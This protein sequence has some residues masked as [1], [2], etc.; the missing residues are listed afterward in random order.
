MLTTT[1]IEE[2]RRRL[3]I[4]GSKDTSFENA[5]PLNGNEILALVQEGVN[6]KMSTRD[7]ARFI[8]KYVEISGGTGGGS[9]DPS[10]FSATVEAYSSAVAEASVDYDAGEFTFKLGLPKG[11]GIPGPVGPQGPEGPRGKDGP[12]GPQGPAGDIAVTSF[13]A[14]TYR[15]Y[16]PTSEKPIPDTPIGGVWDGLNNF[17]HPVGWGPQDGLERPIWKSSRVFFSDPALNGNW[18]TPIQITGDDGSNGTDG[19]SIEFMYKLTEKYSEADKPTIPTNQELWIPENDGWTDDPSG[20]SPTKQCEWVMFRNHLGNG[21]WTDWKGPSLWAKWGDSG[22]DGSGVEY[23]YWLAPE[24]NKGTP[25]SNPTPDN[26]KNNT[27]YQDTIT[28]YDPKNN[29]TDNPTGVSEKRPYEWVCVRKYRHYI[30]ENG[31]ISEEKM[32]LPYEGPTLWSHYGE[33]GYSGYSVRTL[34]AKGNDNLTPPSYTSNN[35]NPGSNWGAFPIDYNEDMVVWAIDGVFSVEGNLVEEW[36]PPRIITGIKGSI[37]VPIYYTSSYFTVP[38]KGAT[39][40]AP[41]TGISVDSTI[42]SK[43]T[44]GQTLTWVDVPNDMSKVWY[45]CV[46]KV[47]SETKKV[48]EWGAV[49]IWNSVEDRVIDGTNWDI[50]V[51]IIS[52]DDLDGPDINRKALNPNQGISSAP[53]KIPNGNEDLIVGEG[54]KMWETKAKFNPDGSF[55]SDGWCYPYP[56]SGEKGPKGDTGPVGDP[57][58]NGVAGISYEE[59]YMRGNETSPMISWSDSYSTLRI[60]SSWNL[61]IPTTNSDYPYIWCIKARINGKNLL[62]DGKW[63]GP[64]RLSGINGVNGTDANPTT[65]ATLTNP[66]DI[67]VSDVN[68]NIINGLPVSTT[69]KIYDGD[70]EAEI[71]KA[72]FKCEVLNN[73]SNYVGM[74]VDVT[75]NTMTI[76]SIKPGAPKSIDIK[77]SAKAK[78]TGKEYFQIFTLKILSSSDI[79]IQADLSNESVVFP[80]RPTG[81]LLVN[82]SD[83]FFNLYIG[84]TPLKDL[85]AIYLSNDKAAQAT[86]T[87]V[88]FTPTK[89]SNDKYTGKFNLTLTDNAF[90]TDVLYVYVTAKCTHEGKQHTRTLPIRLTRIRNGEGAKWY[91]FNIMP[92][93][94]TYD[95]NTN[96]FNTNNIFVGLKSHNG[97]SIADENINQE[98]LTISVYADNSPEKN[99]TITQENNSLEGEGGL[100]QTFTDLEERLVF[101]LKNNEGEVLDRETIP[102][103]TNGLGTTIFRLAVSTDVIQYNEEGVITN[104]KAENVSCYVVMQKAGESNIKI[105]SAQLAEKY[106]DGLDLKVDID[107]DIRDYTPGEAIDVYTPES[108]ISFYLV[109]VLQE[110]D[111]VIDYKSILV[112]KPQ[113]GRKGQLVYPAGTYSIYETY[114][115]TDKVAP[116]V[117]D[118]YDGKFYVLNTIM[119]WKG[120]EQ[121]QGYNTPALNYQDGNNPKAVWIPFD[122]YEAIYADIGVFNQALVGSAVFY[123]EFIFSQKGIDKDGNE[124]SHYEKFLLDENGVDLYGTGLTSKTNPY[125]SKC[126][127]KPTFCI[128]CNTGSSYFANGKVAFLGDGTVLMGFSGRDYWT[129]QGPDKNGLAIYTDGSVGIANGF[130]RLN[131]NGFLIGKTSKSLC[132]FNNDGSGQLSGGIISWDTEGNIKIGKDGSEI[133]FDK[134]GNIEN[135]IVNLNYTVYSN[136]QSVVLKNRTGCTHNIMTSGN[137]FN[138]QYVEDFESHISSGYIG[139]VVVFN[140]GTNVATFT[141]SY[142][143]F[144]NSEKPFGTYNIPAMDMACFKMFKYGSTIFYFVQYR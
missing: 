96:K 42:T 141:I 52:K 49:S 100:L 3:Q 117:L 40:L 94:L 98:G 73:A 131:P 116:Y 127:F 103:L 87:G 25:P 16:I 142:K 84:T 139:D 126:A 83:N 108:S 79:P 53:W 105:D 88:T 45:Q 114:I 113:Y 60:P 111:L 93:S 43:D 128:D 120:S 119:T 29:W 68:G 32:W 26:W 92:Q 62:E 50:R 67:V 97:E 48:V 122:M 136:N 61:K 137:N 72:S 135:S 76:T 10:L 47:N 101:E 15:T 75:T 14:E 112:L 144:A 30:D 109:D 51:A 56:I 74:T 24:G 21:E 132:K 19:E 99:V 34:Y 9:V 46:A 125:N 78:K 107:G 81:E 140:R 36:T 28:E 38:S 69:L 39:P 138:I 5:R 130:A 106:L 31:N 80:A 124:S 2:L 118:T 85:D 90:T 82:D 44:L 35:A 20:I 41:A 65:I 64:F 63:E 95:P 37:E 77:I 133:L 110:P 86:Y 123:K 8:A 17:E 115:T 89:N 33:N 18:S 11:E 55:A 7:F 59:R 57:G 13:T 4:E 6:K 143:F 129:E 70:G 71:N 54:Q 104:P 22:Q 134:N 1:Q 58:A 91:E 102:V 27:L 121:P 12:Q 66:T 23:I